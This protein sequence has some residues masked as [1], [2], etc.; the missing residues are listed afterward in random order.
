MYILILI[1]LNYFAHCLERILFEGTEMKKLSFEDFP[2]L[3]IAYEATSDLKENP[4]NAR[5]HSEKQLAKIAKSIKEF[6]FNLP[7][8]I[9]SDG[10][11]ISGHALFKVAKQLGLAEVPTV[12]ISHLNEP[13]K[14]AF[15]IAMNKLAEESEWDMKKLKLELEFLTEN[16]LDLTITGFDVPQIDL[17]LNDK[18]IEENKSNKPDKADIVPEENKVVPRVNKGDIWKLGNSYLYCGDA[19]EE[20]SFIRLLGDKTAN[21][22]LSDPPYN[23][24]IKDIVGLG[25]IKHEEFSQASGEMTQD[26]FI[27]F[28]ETAFKNLAKFSVDG[29]I[30]FLFMDWKHAFEIMTAGKEVYTELK[31]ICVWNKMQGGMGS[32]YRSQHELVFVFK[33]GKGKHINNIELGKHGRY[34]TNVWDY[35][36]VS[37]TNPGSLED[38]KL[39]PTV[40]PINMLMDA[41]LDCSKASDIILD[42]FAGSGSTLLAAEKTKRKAYVIEYEPKYC[43]VILYRYEKLFKK[44]CELVGNFGGVNNG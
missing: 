27:A 37:V 16:S 42:C 3:K 43:D 40:K 13:Q 4:C 24:K 23:V 15:M 22:I 32:L 30:H 8:L 25:K 11:I 39:H 12:S 41:I 28:L 5:V 31:N 36:G 35:K 1:P 33:N 38:L 29:S 20:E 2:K 9:D 18:F 21:L 14:R 10:T 44:E 26:E 7:I 19:L 34:R 6:G 17:I